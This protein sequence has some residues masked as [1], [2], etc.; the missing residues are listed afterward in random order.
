MINFRPRIAI[1][2]RLAES[3]SVTRYEAIV[4]A[5]KLAELIWDAGGEPLTFLPVNDEKW[6]SRLEGIDGILMPGGADVD[7]KSYGQGHASKEL[8]GLNALQD[9]SDISLVNYALQSDLPLFTIC[10]GTQIANVALGGT[11]IQHMEKPHL[12]E[13]STIEFSS[14]DADLGLKESSLLISCFHHQSLDQLAEGIFP[15]AYA[16][17]GHVEALRYRSNSW[18]FGVQWHPE[19]NYKEVPGQLEIVKTFINAARG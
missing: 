15:L 18:A 8:Y 4:T 10:R 9:Q 16:N 1:P 19:D 11:L 12:N 17:E 7:P 2:A 14:F 5:R 3:S 13:T 6:E